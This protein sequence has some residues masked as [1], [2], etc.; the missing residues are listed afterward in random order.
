MRCYTILRK[1]Q[2]PH[3]WMNLYKVW[4]ENQKWIDRYKEDLETCICVCEE[5]LVMGGKRGV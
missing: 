1:I 3:V 4:W 5:T 2:V